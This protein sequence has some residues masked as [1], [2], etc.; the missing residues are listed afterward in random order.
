MP[1]LIPHCLFIHFISPAYSPFISFFH[2]VF[3]SFS[4]S[5]HVLYIYFMTLLNLPHSLTLLFKTIDPHFFFFKLGK[6]TLL[7]IMTGE[8]LPLTGAVRPHAH[9]RISKFTQHFIDA[10]DLSMTPLDYFL[11]V[12]PDLTREDGRKFLGRFGI[13]GYIDISLFYL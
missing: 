10:L 12:W 5:L 11:A 8:L 6:S 7:K 13:S 4:F 1:Y 2:F 9:L 3:P